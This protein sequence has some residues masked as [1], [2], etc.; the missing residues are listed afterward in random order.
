MLNY[1]LKKFVQKRDMINTIFKLIYILLKS[2]RYKQKFLNK[3]YT[4]SHIEFLSTEHTMLKKVFLKE[5][6]TLFLKLHM[7]KTIKTKHSYPRVKL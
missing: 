1:H 2:T 7:P 5:I 4:P 3:F 6:R